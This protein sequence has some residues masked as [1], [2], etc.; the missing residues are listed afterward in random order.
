MSGRTAYLD[1]SAFL[2]L[3]V[4]EP[5]SDALLSALVRWQDRASASLLRTEAIRALRRAGQ[6]AAIGLARR[7]L[8]GMFLIRLDE[9]LLDRAGELNPLGL[10]SLDAIHLAAA[11]A[12]GADLAVFL[13]YDSR[14]AEA[15]GAVGLAVEA[16]V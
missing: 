10:R 9:P 13:T 2:K 7:L 11:L 3:V 4:R 6:D 15:A 12:V 5:E 8:E 16:P 1:T 14:L